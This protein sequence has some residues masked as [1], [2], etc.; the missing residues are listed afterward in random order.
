[1]R[2]NLTDDQVLR[3]F[4][5]ALGALPEPTRL[6]LMGSREFTRDPDKA[7]RNFGFVCDQL[8]SVGLVAT[9]GW[10]GTCIIRTREPAPVGYTEF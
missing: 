3:F 9:V 7:R 4:N 1:M 5:G 10:N 8:F 6:M 2:D